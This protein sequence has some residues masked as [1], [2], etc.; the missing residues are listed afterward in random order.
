M[1]AD[2]LALGKDSIIYGIGS[3]ITRFVLLATLPLFTAYLS[4]EEY[5]VLAMLALLTMVTQP[6]FS[7]GITAAMGP[8]YFEQDDLPNKS[9]VIWSAFAINV[10]GAAVLILLAW[11][12]RDFFSKL[13]GLPIAYSCLIGYSLTGTALTLLVS[14][15]TLR[16]Q[17][18][19]RAKLYVGITVATALTAIL[20][21]IYTVV[22][23]GWGVKGMVYGQVA[24]NAV[25]FLAFFANG[26][27]ATNFGVS[28]HFIKEH[29]RLGIPLVP[30]FIFVLIL[31]YS[32][33]YILEWHHGLAAVGIY[34]IGFNLGMALSII[35]SGITMAWYPFFMS[36]MNKQDQAKI[37]FGKILTYYFFTIGYICLVFFIFSKPIVQ[38]LTEDA[39]HAAYQV[40]GFVALANFSQTIFIFF[41]PGLYYCKEVK[42][43]SILQGIAAFMSFPL[44]YF[45]IAEYHIVGAA[46]GLF[47][48]N[49]L[50][51]ALLYI[52]NTLRSD[53][54][55]KIEYEWGRIILISVVFAL[56]IVVNASTPMPT[57]GFNLL[58]SFALSL[59]ASVVLMYLLKPAER[60]TVLGYLKRKHKY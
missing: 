49:L 21:S 54:Y 60:E 19:K 43:V 18:E 40:I 8:S 14:S 7:L 6:I 15:F 42:Y 4:P 24:G 59:A 37:I 58:K 44:S 12:M 30:G 26:L 9:K 47:V 51:A 10:V 53:K 28:S 22:F 55:L 16:I 45:L 5:G 1:K 27:R 31:M 20:V 32:N 41:L 25:T 38:L 34:S 33:K 48:G 35:T 17:F 11:S 52:W 50:M 39:F 29:L 57:L 56:F 2:I 13:L 36:Y 46:V 23:L 3:V